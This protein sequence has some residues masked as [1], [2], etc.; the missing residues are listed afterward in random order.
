M[1][2]DAPR[3]RGDRGEMFWR[4]APIGAVMRHSHQASPARRAMSQ[5]QDTAHAPARLSGSDNLKRHE[6]LL[7]EMRALEKDKK[8]VLDRVYRYEFAQP[9]DDGKLYAPDAFYGKIRAAGWEPHEYIFDTKEIGGSTRCWKVGELVL[10]AKD[11]NHPLAVVPLVF[12]RGSGPKAKHRAVLHA[13]TPS[14][15][16][17][18]LNRGAQ[19]NAR[20]ATRLL[21]TFSEESFHASGTALGTDA[22]RQLQD[23]C[24]GVLKL[25]AKSRSGDNMDDEQAEA[26]DP[27]AATG[28][29]PRAA[30]K[31]HRAADN[32]AIE[33]AESSSTAKFQ[34]H[35][36]D[37]KE[38]EK[39]VK[40]DVKKLNGEIDE[41]KQ[42]VKE[43]DARLAET[44]KNH[45]DDMTAINN[46]LQ[47]LKAKM[48][49]GSH[50]LPPTIV[51][52]STPL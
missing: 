28:K 26:D 14:T 33:P 7:E 44:I 38:H 24:F 39:V 50:Q 16:F 40:K 22:L 35:V 13:Q 15:E 32:D 4:A 23:A 25:D 6:Q 21:D 8:L 17:A 52:V 20:F 41:L 42:R 19:H 5:A 36:H 43:L 11:K 49:S 18:S 29:P 1:I 34:Q 37:E 30:S 45:A 51:A 46:K 47:K 3:L 31:R 12:L 2:N 27:P 9:A 10:L 48:P